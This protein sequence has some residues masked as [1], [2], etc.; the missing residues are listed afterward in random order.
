MYMGIYIM[1]ALLSGLCAFLTKKYAKN[2]YIKL[3]V[4]KKILETVSYIKPG[5]D[6]N[7]FQQIYWNQKIFI[8]CI[9]M[10]GASIFS[11]LYQISNYAV[12]IESTKRVVTLKRPEIGEGTKMYQLDIEAGDT[13]KEKNIE[14]TI[15]ERIAREEEAEEAFSQIFQVI[16]TEMLGENTSFDEIQRNLNL[17]V[18]LKQY[19][20]QITWYSDNL[21]LIDSKGGVHNQYLEEA[22]QVRITADCVYSG[23]Q[24][25]FQFDLMLIPQEKSA[26]QDYIKKIQREIMQQNQ[27]NKNAA[28][29]I[30][31]KEIEGI[32]IE[33]YL[34]E[35]AT[36][37]TI[38]F[39]GLII[40]F[41]CILYADQKIIQEKKKKEEE[42][43]LSYPEIIAKMTLLIRAGLT[44]R[45]AWERI[46]MDYRQ[47]KKHQYAY[48]EM[49]YTYYEME[50]GIPEA[51]AY[52]EF[53]RRCQLASYKKFGNLLEQN[54]KK[55]SGGLIILLEQE[56]NLAFEARK[57]LALKLG[58]EAGT[59]LLLPMF[60][61]LVVVLVVCIAPAI[62]SF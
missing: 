13:V 5:R 11:I 34:A 20:C 17:P 2:F 36:D 3:P 48:E 50:N 37:N 51:K 56:A 12:P 60:F 57:S 41:I 8:F 31:P 10:A 25:E 44:L 49:E 29:I 9:I 58:E 35:E 52:R 39:L 23:Y 22:Q 4:S 62:L 43:M 54:L 55:G 24:K 14:I 59:K 30:L 53:G 16:C 47:Q 40:G 21:E 18:Y 42:L 45:K 27:I 46:V 26:E 38:L 7:K 28:E 15:S 6:N 19:P 32:P 33:Y 61:M 1:L